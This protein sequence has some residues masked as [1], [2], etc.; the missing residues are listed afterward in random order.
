MCQHHVVSERDSSL[1]QTNL[2]EKLNLNTFDSAGSQ[3]I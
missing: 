2:P 1:E 3:S